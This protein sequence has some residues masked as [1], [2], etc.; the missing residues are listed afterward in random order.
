[1]SKR[2]K[3]SIICTVLNKGGIS[4]CRYKEKNIYGDSIQENTM[5]LTGTYYKVVTKGKKGN[6]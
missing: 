5:T 3:E 6:L 2:W 4:N 1:M